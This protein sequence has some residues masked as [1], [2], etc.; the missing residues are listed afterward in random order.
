MAAVATMGC[1]S[2]GGDTPAARGQDIATRSGCTSCHGADGGGG[3]GPAWRGLAGSKVRIAGRTVDGYQVFLGADLDRHEL[4]EVVGRVAEEH[5]GRAVDAIV[6]TW[7]ALRHHGET[8]GRTARRI[9]LDG[10][11]NQVTASL[12]DD[13]ALGAEPATETA[14]EITTGG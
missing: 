1:S 3:V 8:L 7:E 6:G 14:V 4:G 11:A 5:L 9:G 12:H 13:W 2:S 10:F